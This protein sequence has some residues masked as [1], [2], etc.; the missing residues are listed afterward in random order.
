ME[1]SNRT[2]AIIP[3]NLYSQ[4]DEMNEILEKIGIN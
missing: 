1:I 2:N 4:T 3:V